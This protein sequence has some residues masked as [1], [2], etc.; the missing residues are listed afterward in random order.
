MSKRSEEKED[1]VDV[2]RLIRSIQKKEGEEPCFMTEKRF[3]CKKIDCKWRKYCLK[4]I[5]R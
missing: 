4:G 2:I 3:S 1:W 5:K